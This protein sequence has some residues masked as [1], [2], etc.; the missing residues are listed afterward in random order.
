M[1]RLSKALSIFLWVFFVACAFAEDSNSDISAHQPRVQGSQFTFSSEA[2]EGQRMIDLYLPESYETGSRS[3]PIIYVLDSDFLFDLT[4]AVAKNRWSRELA[5]E[6][7]VV[8]IQSSNNHQ[9][10][11]FAMPMKRAD[12]SVSFSN[13]NPDKQAAFLQNELASYLNSEYRTNGFNVIVGMSPTAT[14]VIYDYLSEKPFFDAH[15]AIAADIQFSTLQGKPIH[16]AIAD[17]TA[18]GDFIIVSRGATDLANNP[19]LEPAFSALSKTTANAPGKVISLLPNS[20]EHYSVAL[21]TMDA[22]LSALFPM[23]VWRPNYNELRAVDNP[24]EE[25]KSFYVNLQNQVGFEV[26]PL[27]DGYWMG[28]SIL[29]LT[30]FLVRNDKSKE[31]IELL[32]WADGKL[33]GNPW[34]LYYFSR[35]YARMEQ[36]DQ[37]L[38]YAIESSARAE[39]S[40]HADSDLFQDN[41]TRVKSQIEESRS[42]NQLQM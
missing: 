9:R 28:N 18:E 40:L 1:I 7:I 3:Y 11:N 17:K 2:L 24:V 41:V 30:R 25:L 13:S 12:G 36:L 42:E 29:G 32:E 23:D 14:N 4:V 8:G 20:T 33:A 16:K 19:D 27:L 35:V 38:E 22:G 39:Q 6:A 21:Q 34:I 37:A 15:I 26:Y 31:A 5:P 10:F